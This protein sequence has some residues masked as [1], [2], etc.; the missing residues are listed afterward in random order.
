MGRNALAW[1]GSKSSIS[2]DETNSSEKIACRRIRCR[3]SANSVM[4]E[5]GGFFDPAFS[6]MLLFKEANEND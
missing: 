3:I 6:N 4:R 1:L 2:A 5:E